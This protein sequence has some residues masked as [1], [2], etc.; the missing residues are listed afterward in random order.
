MGL[1]PRGS[2]GS[3][4]PHS[5]PRKSAARPRAR[6]RP[7][8][9]A[10]RGFAPPPLARTAA[11]SMGGKGPRAPPRRSGPQAAARRR[12]PLLQSPRIPADARGIAAGA[13]ASGRPDS[14]CRERKPR[15]RGPSRA[16]AP[17]RKEPGPRPRGMPRRKHRLRRRLQPRHPRRGAARRDSPQQRHCS[18]PPLDRFAPARGIRQCPHR[19]RHPDFR[20]RLV[21]LR[22]GG[23]PQ[24]HAAWP[25]RRRNRARM[26]PRP[27]IRLRPAYGPR[28]LPLPPARHAR[29]RRAARASA[30]TRSSFPRWKPGP[31]RSW[32]PRTTTSSTRATG[33][34]PFW[35]PTMRIP[36]KS[37]PGASATS[38]WIPSGS[39]FPTPPGP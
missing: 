25:H 4:G 15:S 9:K 6:L 19:K 38:A 27:R 14:L 32:S 1:C 29:R 20:Q 24:S 13:H 35:R 16:P 23:R 11:G 22:S 12:H 17:R 26:A 36:A 37:S 28:L 39:P 34:S 31:A 10:D 5:T 30:P 21:R 2:A 33:S 8:A 18:Q 3:A 7:Q